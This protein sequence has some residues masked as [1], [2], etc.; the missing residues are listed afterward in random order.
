[1]I[2]YELPITI[3]INNKDF[4]ITNKGDFRM[5][6]DCFSALSDE[7]VPEKYRILDALTIFYDDINSDNDI[8]KVFG[9]YT[10]EAIEKMYSFFNCGQQTI[11]V[12][13]KRNLIDW[14]RDA[15]LVC[16]A[17]NQVAQTEIRSEPYLHWFTFMGYYISISDSVLATVVNIRDK[18]AKGKKLEKH[19]KEFVHN[20]PEFFIHKQSESEQEA[21]DEWI[22]NNWNKKKRGCS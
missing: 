4:A 18:K 21:S 12:K 5:I 17:V 22:R 11:G 19:E 3:E 9:D 14:E 7:M 20:N 16:A 6:L 1:M 13:S 10:Q 15:Q 8:I 2:G